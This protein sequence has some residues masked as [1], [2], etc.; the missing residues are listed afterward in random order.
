MRP[1]A[2]SQSASTSRPPSRTSGRV[3]RSGACW[4]ASR[5]DPSDRAARG[6]PGRPARPRTPT[7][8]PS[9]TAMSKAVAVGVQHGRRSAPSARRRPPP[10]RRRA[11]V[12]AHRP[13]SPAP[14]RR[15]RTPRIG[16]AVGHARARAY[17]PS[18]APYA[19]VCGRGLRGRPPAWT[20]E[21]TGRPFAVVTGAS[22]GIGHELAKQFAQHGFDLLIAAEDAGID[23]AGA[24][25]RRDGGR[26]VQAVRVDL[27]T[28][29]G[30]EELY[31]TIVATGRPGRRDRAQRR[32][33]RR[34]RLRPR[35][36]PARR[37][38]HHRPQ[39]HLDRAPRQA[40][41]A[42]HGRPRRGQG[43]VH[44]VDRLDDAGP[45]QAV[46]NASKSFVQSFAE[47][48]ATS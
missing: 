46:Y 39:R 38:Q 16:D 41:A 33:R 7:I 45:F 25:L 24:R 42:R 18:G 36:R 48:S 23:D 3:S 2:V 26:P 15:A 34:R 14:V 20:H 1:I 40:R 44:L 28:Y 13:G 27:A 37:A 12:D 31:R 4:P 35:H 47:A 21:T 19:S 32:A 11:A 9:L 6:S 10:A 30:V 5:T 17:P 29:E 43:P 22:S 8:R